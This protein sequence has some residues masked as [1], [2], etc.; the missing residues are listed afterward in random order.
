MAGRLEAPL[1]HF[2]GLSSDLNLSRTLND[3]SGEV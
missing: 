2:A 1:N 3:Y